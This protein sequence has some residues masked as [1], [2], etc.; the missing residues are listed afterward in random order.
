MLCGGA[1][2][3]DARLLRAVCRVLELP[4]VATTTAFT[5]LHRVHANCGGAES[6]GA[7]V[8]SNG[9]VGARQGNGSQQQG[10]PYTY[11]TSQVWWL[12]PR[13]A[14]HVAAAACLHPQ[15][16]GA[17]CQV[18]RA[19]PHDARTLHLTH[20]PPHARAHARTHPQELVCACIYLAS[21]VEEVRG[22]RGSKD[23]GQAALA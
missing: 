20:A 4:A 23:A 13:S 7:A 10:P 16:H 21:K 12:A 19:A 22:Q 6:G 5:F 15:P 17:V 9:G 3:H 18:K 1:H 8:G 14:R 2:A 11:V